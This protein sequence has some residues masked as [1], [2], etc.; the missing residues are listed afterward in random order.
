MTISMP[1]SSTRTARDGPTVF[2]TPARWG[3]RRTYDHHSYMEE[4]KEAMDKLANCIH[5]I[6]SS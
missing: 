1:G 6:V 3:V 4:K 5:E 2:A